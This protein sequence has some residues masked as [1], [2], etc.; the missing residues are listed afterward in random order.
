MALAAVPAFLDIDAS[1]F[2]RDSYPVEIGFVLRSVAAH[3]P[4]GPNQF[5]A[6][7]RSVA[8]DAAAEGLHISAREVAATI[9]WLLRGR[10]SFRDPM[11]QAGALQLAA[12][13]YKE[14]GFALE[15]VMSQRVTAPRPEERMSEDEWAALEAWTTDKLNPG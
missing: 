8:A 5:D 9:R 15:R 1:G 10:V 7:T 14:V 3:S 2:G 4:F 11:P 13:L 12:A 6:V